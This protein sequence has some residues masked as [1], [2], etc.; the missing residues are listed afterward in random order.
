M[1]YEIIALEYIENTNEILGARLAQ[2]VRSL[3]LTAHTI[4][5]PIRRG[6]APSF[7]NYK[8]G[9]TWLAAANIAESGVKHQKSSQI[10]SNEILLMCIKQP[11]ILL[12]K[13]CSYLCNQR[14]SQLKL[15]VWIPLM[16][17]C[18]QYNIMSSS[19]SVTWG[20]S[21]VFSGY[22][23]SSINKPGRHGITEILLKVALN[24]ITPFFVNE[25]YDSCCFFVGSIKSWDVLYISRRLV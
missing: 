10:K 12:I 8:K 5:S 24:T 6:F 19:L 23:G 15:W 14:I 16:T 25:K 13:I 9:C 18:T 4:L 20:M 21:V 3:D 17:R 2:W 7:V 1:C 22:S 11:S